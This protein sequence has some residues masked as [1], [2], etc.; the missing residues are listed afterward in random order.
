MAEVIYKTK[1]DIE[2]VI[3]RGGKS[4]FDFIVRYRDPRRKRIRTPKHIHLVVDLFAKKTGNPILY[5]EIIDYILNVIKSI[6]PS[7]TTTPN[8]QIFRS[9][10]EKRF[11]PLNDFGEYSAEFL[12]VTVELIMIQEKTNYP[13]GT[14]NLRLFEKLRNSDDIYS[15]VSSATFR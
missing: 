12:L 11:E 9:G 5:I 3:D 13:N 10:D 4:E 2:I 15:I 7:T 1:E 6:K 8:L 14:L